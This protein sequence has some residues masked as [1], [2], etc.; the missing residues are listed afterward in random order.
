[1]DSLPM[2]HPRLLENTPSFG[3]EKKS[4]HGVNPTPIPRETALTS[5]RSLG[6]PHQAVP[7][8]GLNLR[9]HKMCPPCLRRRFT[10][11]WLPNCSLVKE[12]DRS[13]TARKQ[14]V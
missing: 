5:G 10:S 11:S 14:S 9:F 7:S 12:P 6:P 4:D 2:T 13:A 3:F 1:L 8:L